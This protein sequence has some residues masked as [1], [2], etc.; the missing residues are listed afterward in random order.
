M[1]QR[2]SG[3]ERVVDDAYETPEWARLA[4]VLF[5]AAFTARP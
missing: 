2:E 5:V 3:Y 4:L 1:S